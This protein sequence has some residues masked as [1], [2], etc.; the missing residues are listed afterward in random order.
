M[1]GGDGAAQRLTDTARAMS[2]GNLELHH[3]SVEAFN[4]RDVEAW[5]EF[6]HPDIELHSAVTV[7]GGAVYHGHDGVRRWHRDLAEAFGDEV[8]IE[9]EAWLDRG[10]HT[11]S[12][13]LLRGRGRQSGAEV[14]MP[15]AHVH[16]W[17]D[18]LIVYFRGYGDRREVLRDL[19]VSAD[20]FR[21]IVP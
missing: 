3:R 12:F 15:A 19:G 7:P 18:G 21:P 1:V 4:S 6:C 9:P 14:A 8:R 10:E 13:H 17:L 16:R 2:P 5:L 11:A 20:D